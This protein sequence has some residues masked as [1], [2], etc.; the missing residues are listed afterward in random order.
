M[1]ATTVALSVLHPARPGRAALPEISSCWTAHTRLRAS[2]DHAGMGGA[3]GRRI[4]REDPIPPCGGWLLCGPGSRSCVDH[5][6]DRNAAG[7]TRPAPQADCQWRRALIRSAGLLR[8]CG[9]AAFTANF[10]FNPSR[11]GC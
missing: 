6:S 3:A 2:E 11:A 4:G 5:A 7:A 10:L 8:H 9:S 1:P